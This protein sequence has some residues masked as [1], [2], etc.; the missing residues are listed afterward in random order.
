MA[1]FRQQGNIDDY[2]CAIVGRSL[3]LRELD[4]R[5]TIRELRST[6]NFEDII[7]RRNKVN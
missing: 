1:G 4:T 2:L 3:V 5:V 7:S 6:F